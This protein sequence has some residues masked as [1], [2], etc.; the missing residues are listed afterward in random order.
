MSN[1]KPYFQDIDASY[2]GITALI[3]GDE[4]TA[5]KFMTRCVTDI[6]EIER[7]MEEAKKHLDILQSLKEQRLNAVQHT[8]KHLHKEYPAVIVGEHSLIMIDN[9]LCTSLI[10]LTF[11][12]KADKHS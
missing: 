2:S 12:K 5:E 7:S 6:V 10:P 8:M 4:Q 11:I 3:D 9:D 1:T